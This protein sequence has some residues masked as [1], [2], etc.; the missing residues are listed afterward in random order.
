MCAIDRLNIVAHD[1]F[2]EIIDEATDPI[3]PSD[4]SRSFSILM[5]C[6][7][8]SVTIVSQPQIAHKLGLRPI[9]AALLTVPGI[10]AHQESVAFAKPEEQKVV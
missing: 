3:L 6:G 5:N 9:G 4:C 2:Q 8:K 7:K 1:R 10:N